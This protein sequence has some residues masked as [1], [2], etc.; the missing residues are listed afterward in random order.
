[1]VLQPRHSCRAGPSRRRVNESRLHSLVRDQAVRVDQTGADVVGLQPWVAGQNRL[2]QIAGGEHPED[3]FDGQPPATDHRLP[4]EDLWV[5]GDACK[6][7]IFAL[8]RHRQPPRRLFRGIN[9]ESSM[10]P[11][12]AASPIGLSPL[13]RPRTSAAREANGR[14]AKKGSSWILVRL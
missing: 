14:A 12:L 2:G 6:K 3:V 1:H 4:T 8:S 10:T 7:I 11:E 13:R 5:D 9:L